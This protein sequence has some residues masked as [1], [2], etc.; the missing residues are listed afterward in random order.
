M[1]KLIIAIGILVI[2][3]S[4]FAANTGKKVEAAKFT[5]MP[6]GDAGPMLPYNFENTEKQTAWADS[7]KP[8]FI[9]YTARHGARYLTSANKFKAAW[10]ALQAGSEKGMLTA[11]GEALKSYLEYIKNYSKGKW[12]LLSK[13]GIREEERLGA[14]MAE[15]FPELMKKGKTESISTAVPRVIMTMDQFLHSLEIPNQN[16]QLYT[17]AGKQND[18]IL[19]GFAYYKSYRE[20]RDTGNN[21]P[22]MK[23]A[24]RKYVS[25]APAKRLF[26]KGFIKDDNEL[27]EIT[28]SIYS[29]LQ[30]VNASGYK[31][32]EIQFLSEK[33]SYGCWQ[34]N[35]FK[36]YLLN[37]INPWNSDAARATMPLLNKIIADVDKAAASSKNG[38]Y[39]EVRFCGN[40]GH[41]ETL[42]PLLSLMRLGDGYIMTD[43]YERIEKEWIVQDI[44]PLAANIAVVLL[45]SPKGEMYASV[46]LN[47]KNMKP[48]PGKGEVVK[49]EELKAYWQGLCKEYLK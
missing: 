45:C 33:E 39:P 5:G 18:S 12:G 17:A 41:A 25:T 16:L 34:A 29:A 43:S 20:F 36:H 35:N 30:G 40:F 15:M 44:T 22:V 23:K 11:D 19:R 3:A 49:W 2:A 47:G 4:G 37:S 48:V 42:L 27:R 32:P 21:N 38:S 7:L 10:N 31:N 26:K 8:I 6:A 24:M 9:S 46:R 14:D 13:T 1:K 28:Y